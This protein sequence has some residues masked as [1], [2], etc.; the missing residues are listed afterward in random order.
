MRMNGK[1]LLKHTR[2][3][4]SGWLSNAPNTFMLV[5][6]QVLRP[7]IEKYVVSFYDIPI[8]NSNLKRASSTYARYFKFVELRKAIYYH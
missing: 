3:Y 6:N 4:M 8:Y 7:F 5:M 1:L 2:V